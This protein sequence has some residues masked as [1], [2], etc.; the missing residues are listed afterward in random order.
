MTVGNVTLE[1][2]A[3]LAWSDDL[4]LG[5]P[6]MD[7]EHEAFVTH[8][9]ALQTASDDALDACYQAFA[10]HAKAHFDQEN[11]WM[12]ETQFPPR[13]CHIDEHAAVLKSVD[14]VGALLAA[15]QHAI[16]RELAQKVAE[17]FPAHLQHLDSALSHWVCKRRWGG[18]PVVLRR[19]LRDGEDDQPR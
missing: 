2:P 12:E 13:Q 4:L 6:S 15:G 16:A 14:E 18:K 7:A 11:A 3:P 8:L 9:H 10:E 17:W 1:A 5:E 19:G